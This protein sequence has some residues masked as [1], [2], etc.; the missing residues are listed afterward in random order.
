MQRRL[1]LKPLKV[2]TKVVTQKE[3]TKMLEVYYQTAI[4]PKE[5]QWQENL[6]FKR[7]TAPLFDSIPFHRPPFGMDANITEKIDAADINAYVYF[8]FQEKCK[9][10]TSLWK[11]YIKYNLHLV[12]LISIVREVSG[13]ACVNLCTSKLNVM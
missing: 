4:K 6:K 11:K 1:L 13:K 12:L 3:S 7:F 8:L 5:S 9:R 10:S 2:Q